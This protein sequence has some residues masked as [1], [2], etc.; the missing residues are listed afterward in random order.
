LDDILEKFVRQNAFEGIYR[1]SLYLE[2][3]CGVAGNE[4]VSSYR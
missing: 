2:R 1:L 3:E 4:I